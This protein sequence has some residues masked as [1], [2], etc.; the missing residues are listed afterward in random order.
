[1]SWGPRA[2][3]SYR[4]RKMATRA[5]MRDARRR[6]YAHPQAASPSPGS[7][8][9][10][11]SPAQPTYPSR[12]AE[13]EFVRRSR[14]EAERDLAYAV[15]ARNI[16]FGTLGALLLTG[17]LPGAAWLGSLLLLLLVA[18]AVIWAI[19]QA[20]YNAGV[21]DG[22]EVDR[23]NCPASFEESGLD[24]GAPA[25]Q[26]SQDVEGT[27]HL[28]SGEDAARQE[29]LRRQALASL[30]MRVSGRATGQKSIQKS[31]SRHNL[32]E[33]VLDQEL[34][35]RRD[36]KHGKFGQ[37]TVGEHDLNPKPTSNAPDQEVPGLERRLQ[38][39]ERKIAEDQ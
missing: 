39:L 25:R 30:E 36:A 3:S 11:H 2:R 21:R 4:F 5:M 7:I 24:R 37:G 12:F 33:D 31:I 22:E 18:E 13:P 14:T 6:D 28:A 38:S 1:M 20:E 34:R 32:Q 35:W 23:S 17:F 8:S 26:S 9:P 15:G 27:A 16:F 19:Y 29:S 10:A